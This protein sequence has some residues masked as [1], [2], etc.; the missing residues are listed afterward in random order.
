MQAQMDFFRSTDDELREEI[1]LLK[2]SHERQRR[3][4]FAKITELS[5]LCS[6]LNQK[7][8][9]LVSLLQEENGAGS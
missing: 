7:V 4:M 6:S 3:A 5:K 1:A 9:L 2:D 8:E